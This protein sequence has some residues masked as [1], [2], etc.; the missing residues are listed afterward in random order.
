MPGVETDIIHIGD[1]NFSLR[2]APRLSW[3]ALILRFCATRDLHSRSTAI[4]T[5]I[6]RSCTTVAYTRHAFFRVTSLDATVLERPG[7]GAGYVL[8]GKRW[9]YIGVC[10]VNFTL[11]RSGKESAKVRFIIFNEWRFSIARSRGRGRNIFKM[12]V[13]SESNFVFSQQ[14]I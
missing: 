13:C 5:E 6:T 1:L 10:C 11:K 4:N 2:S 12:L 14:R 8:S 3:V 9:K 7:I